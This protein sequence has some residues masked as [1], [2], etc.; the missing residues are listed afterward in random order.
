MSTS[1]TPTLYGEV[2]STTMPSAASITTLGDDLAGLL[3]TVLLPP[4]E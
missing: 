4:G 3:H 2:V 1:V